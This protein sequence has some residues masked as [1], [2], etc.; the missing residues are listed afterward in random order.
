MVGLHPNYIDLYFLNINHTRDVINLM[1]NKGVQKPIA[2]YHFARTQKIWIFIVILSFA[3]VNADGLCIDFYKTLSEG[4]EID[5]RSKIFAE[6]HFE[7]LG[8]N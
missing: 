6:D 7:S 1:M 8:Q 4:Q 3:P 2:D 5:R